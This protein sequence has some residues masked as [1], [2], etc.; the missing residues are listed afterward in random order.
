LEDEGVPDRVEA[1]DAAVEH[2]DVRCA[3][4]AVAAVEGADAVRA[5]DHG[6]RCGAGLAA[7]GG[8]ALDVAA[9]GPVGSVALQLQSAGA[10]LGDPCLLP[11]AGRPEVAGLVG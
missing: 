7:A 5:E 8:R 9:P 10:D 2:L 11:V 6:D 3:Q 4:P 1:R